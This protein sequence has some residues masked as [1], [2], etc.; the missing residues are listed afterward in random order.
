VKG[1]FRGESLEIG[2][3]WLL[4]I[5]SILVTLEK[6]ILAKVFL[7]GMTRPERRLETDVDHVG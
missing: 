1:L 3:R 2:E 4:V 7:A 6:W 5:E